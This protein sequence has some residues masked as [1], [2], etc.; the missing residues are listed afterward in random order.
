MVQPQLIRDLG[1]RRPRA[2]FALQRT[3]VDEPGASKLLPDRRGRPRDHDGAGVPPGCRVASGSPSSRC[4]CACRSTTGWRGPP[5]RRWRR[6]DRAVRHAAPASQCMRDQV[7]GSG[8]MRRF[9]PI[10]SYEVDDLRPRGFV[11]AGL[12]SRSCP[13]WPGCAAVLGRCASSADRC[14]RAPDIGADLVG[15]AAAASAADASAGSSRRFARHPPDGTAPTPAEASFRRVR[16]E[17]ATRIVGSRGH[18]LLSV[19]IRSRRR[20]GLVFGISAAA[21]DQPRAVLGR[22]AGLAVG[23]AVSQCGGARLGREVLAPMAFVPWAGPAGPAPA[24][25]RTARP[26]LSACI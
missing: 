15:R 16:R 12:G 26:L 1:R 20:A 5:R 18:V 11:G 6:C 14:R 21:R 8:A 24:S 3:A 23:V 22:C 13:P 19:L 25:S 17:W 4:C 2:Q 10:V 7:V 9:S